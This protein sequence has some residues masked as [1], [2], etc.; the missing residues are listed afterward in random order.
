MLPEMFLVI[1]PKFLQRSQEKKRKIKILNTQ[2][3]LDK[4]KPLQEAGRSPK[5]SHFLLGAKMSC[6]ELASIL[7]IEISKKGG[8][9]SLKNT[10][11]S[12]R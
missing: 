8:G 5:L 3:I 2:S 9:K 7:E 12:S 10:I 6:S 1:L 11:S 4:I